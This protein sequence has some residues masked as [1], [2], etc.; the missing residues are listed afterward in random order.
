MKL[1]YTSHQ[2]INCS[3]TTVIL[4]GSSKSSFLEYALFE[5][6]K[7]LIIPIWN[8]FFLECALFGMCS[9][10]NVLFL[11]CALYGMCHFWSVLKME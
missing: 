7:N 10:W 8:V 1:C 3:T 2:Y 6:T 4:L 5:C 11:E 9:F